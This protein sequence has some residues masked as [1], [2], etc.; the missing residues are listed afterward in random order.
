MDFN[1]PDSKITGTAE[2]NVQTGKITDK[3]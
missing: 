3:Y 2:I 1:N